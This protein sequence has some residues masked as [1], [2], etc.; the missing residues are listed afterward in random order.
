MYKEKFEW[1]NE[2]SVSFLKNKD[3]YIDK[4]EDPIQRLRGISDAAERILGIEGFSDKFFDYLGEGYYSLSSPIWAN[5]GRERSAGISCF[6]SYIADDMESILDTNAEVGYMSKLGGGTSAYFGDIRPRGSKISTGGKSDGAVEFMRLFD[7]TVDVTKQAAVRR[8]VMAC[9]L[10]IDHRDIEEFLRIK[11]EGHPIQH[12]FTGVTIKDQWMKDMIDGDKDKRKIWAKV[13]SSRCETGLPYIFF[14]DTVNNGKS[15]IYKEKDMNIYASNVCAEI[16]LPSSKE[17]SFVCCLSSMNLV[18]YDEWKNTDAVETL[19]QFLDAVMSEFIDKTKNQKH[20]QK[21]RKFAERHRA[22]G[23]GVFGWHSLLQ[24][25]MVPFESMQAKM[26]NN[27]IFKFIDEKSLQASKDMA[28]SHGEPELLKEKGLRFTT[29]TAVAPTTSS[30]FIIGQ[31]SQSIE[32][33]FS[34]FYEKDLAKAR[35]TIKN[36]YLKKLLEEKG[37]DNKVTWNKILKDGGSV[38]GLDI[39]TDEEKEVFRTF[40][41]ISQKEIVIQAA[42]R[43]RYIDQSQSLNLMIDPSTPA[44]EIN[45]LMI[46]AWESG[47]KTLYYQHSINASQ[48]FKRELNAC[49]SCEA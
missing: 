40:A 28:I 16:N 48:K 25:K 29:R 33:Y 49:V 18:K 31:A 14:E 13:I 30:A 2:I 35:I 7:T 36:P 34:N 12:L 3:G 38:Q 44:K 41:E 11:T 5:F 6:G 37:C 4:D 24:S 22:I 8:G 43:Q 23:I 26:L 17:E 1:L 27:E 32:P 20:M 9:Y 10:P 47:V 19:A 45:K 46:F 42:N 39:L 15:D 21:A